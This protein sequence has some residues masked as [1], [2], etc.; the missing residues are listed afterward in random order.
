VKAWYR[1]GFDGESIPNRREF[2][3]ARTAPVNL[4]PAEDKVP[5][6]DAFALADELARQD[7]GEQIGWSNDVKVGALLRAFRKR[8]EKDMTTFK[9]GVE[10]GTYLEPARA[11][12]KRD[13]GVVVMGHTHLVKRVAVE[14]G[15]YLNTGT[16]ADL[17][18]IP[19]AVYAGSELDGRS[20]LEAFLDNIK[21]NRID[22]YRRPVPTFAQIDIDD[23]ATKGDVFFYDGS[24]RV[25]AVT[26]AGLL[27]R[28]GLGG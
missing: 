9:I 4:G 8:R 17:M 28:L 15:V 13:F 25:E 11:L 7:A 5:D 14:G 20:A 24:G 12:A 1:G 2:I 26:D 6:E 27:R 19:E 21:E 16:W 3:A 22:Q 18:C 23:R 10:A